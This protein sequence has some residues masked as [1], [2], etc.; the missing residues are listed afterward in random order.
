MGLARQEDMTPDTTPQKTLMTIV[1]SVETRDQSKRWD[2]VCL[3]YKM[4]LD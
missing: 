3:I 2:Q 4:I 1:S